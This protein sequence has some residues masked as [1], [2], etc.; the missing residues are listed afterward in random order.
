MRHLPGRLASDWKYTLAAAL[1]LGIGALAATLYFRVDTLFLSAARGAQAVAYYSAPYQIVEAFWLVSTS[2]N[3]VMLPVLAR[4]FTPRFVERSIGL[5]LCIGLPASLAISF[6]AEDIVTIVFGSTYLPAALPLRWVIWVVPILFSY[7]P[8][9]TAL[10]VHD[11]QRHVLYVLLANLVLV[12]IL[13]ALLIPPHGVLGASIATVAVEAAGLGG[14]LFLV[15]RADLEIHWT[16]G[17][18]GAVLICLPIAAVLVIGQTLPFVF[19]M[20]AVVMLWAALFAVFHPWSGW[21]VNP[22]FFSPQGAPSRVRQARKESEKTGGE[23]SSQPG[24]GTP[25]TPADDTEAGSKHSA[26]QGMV[27]HESTS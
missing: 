19:I 9:V 26:S 10:F 7:V 15:K 3:G 23:R 8:L 1:P 4:R 12:L 18:G 24:K 2:W 22:Q 17:L 21:E 11:Y 14:Y 16:R 13:D 6:R 5:L 25:Q 27:I 20:P